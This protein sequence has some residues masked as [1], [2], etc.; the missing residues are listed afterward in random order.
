MVWPTG[1]INKLYV[2]MLYYTLFFPEGPRRDGHSQQ[3][4]ILLWFVPY[5]WHQNVSIHCTII[6][7]LPNLLYSIFRYLKASIDSPQLT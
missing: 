7:N 2:I 5:H 3:W 1:I 6:C 4:I